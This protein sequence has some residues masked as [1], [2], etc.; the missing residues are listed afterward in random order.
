MREAMRR[1]RED[2]GEDAIIVS[3]EETGNGVLIM[4]ATERPEAPSAD[5]QEKDEVT[6]EPTLREP[7]D[8]APQTPAEMPAGKP[9][10]I[11]STA[12]AVERCIDFHGLPRPVAA[13]LTA[14]VRSANGGP[15][16]DVLGLALDRMVGFSPIDVAAT[17]HPL[18]MIGDAGAGKTVTL[19]KLATEAR[20]AGRDVAA[21]TADTARSG[22]MEQ[23][24]AFMGAIGADLWPLDRPDDL[25]RLVAMAK[26]GSLVLIDT[27]AVNPLDCESFPLR[28]QLGGS[29]EPVL[30]MAAGSQ[31]DDA[32]EA[33]AAAREVFGVRRLIATRFDTSHRFGAVIAAAR[34]GRISIAGLSA[35]RRIAEPVRPAAPEALA[36]LMLNQIASRPDA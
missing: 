3:A 13:D 35:S 24:A 20:L 1:V 31:A 5:P 17:V 7:R 29:I 33:A 26:P 25:G 15:E 14:I 30:V 32:A 9:S 23:L 28:A 19:A 2:F 10:P 27:P 36:A 34:L 6:A 21:I 18:M 8:P 12:T 4:A 11:R 16:T 22:G